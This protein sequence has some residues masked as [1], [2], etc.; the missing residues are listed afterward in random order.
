MAIEAGD[1]GAGDA[2]GGEQHVAVVVLLVAATVPFVGAGER[3]RV[4]EEV[5]GGVGPAGC[6]EEERAGEESAGEQAVGDLVSDTDVS[7]VGDAIAIP[8][9]GES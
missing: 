1:G 2:T 6:G 5:Q 8:V 9:P 7:S 4:E 3:G